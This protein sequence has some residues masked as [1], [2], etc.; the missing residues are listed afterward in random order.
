HIY[1]DRSKPVVSLAYNSTVS[2]NS[3]YVNVTPTDTVSLYMNCTVGSTTAT[4][5]NGD[6]HSYLVPLPRMKKNT[7]RITCYDQA[8]NKARK[9][10][11]ITRA[12]PA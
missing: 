11:R 9:T 1:Y 5:A 12:L 7:V 3:T 6:A 8:M 10:I 2:A 4:I